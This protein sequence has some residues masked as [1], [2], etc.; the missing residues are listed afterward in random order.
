MCLCGWVFACLSACVHGRARM[1]FRL[2][3]M[4]GQQGHWHAFVKTVPVILPLHVRVRQV[5]CTYVAIHAEMLPPF[6]QHSAYGPCWGLLL[7]GV[8]SFCLPG[9]GWGVHEGPRVG[10]CPICG[11]AH[12]QRLLHL[13]VCSSSPVSVRLRHVFASDTLFCCHPSAHC[14]QFFSGGELR[15][16]GGPI[17]TL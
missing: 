3:R 9:G 7:C 10:G 2:L 1:A 14:F 12:I 15:R 5:A 8:C 16:P 4:V 13:A 6:N 11:G 17:E